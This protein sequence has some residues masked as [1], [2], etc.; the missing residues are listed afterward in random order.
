LPLAFGEPLSPSAKR[1]TFVPSQFIKRG[2]VLLLEFFKRNRCLVQHAVEFRDLLL[3]LCRSLFRFRSMPI[4]FCRLLLKV[5][6][7]P[8]GS[9]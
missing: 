2:R 6:G 5:Y 3:G 1:P 4:G 7:L 8:I 9:N